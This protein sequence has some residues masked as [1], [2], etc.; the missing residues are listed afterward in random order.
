MCLND[1]F[2]D[3]F[4]S[5][6]PNHLSCPKDQFVVLYLLQVI[7]VLIQDYNW[8]IRHHLTVCRCGLDHILY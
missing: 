8:E 4:F 6:L 2:S 5:L 1:I 7:I 3:S